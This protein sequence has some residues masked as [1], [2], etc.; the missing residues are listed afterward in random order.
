LNTQIST[1]VER[2]EQRGLATLRAQ[3]EQTIADRARLAPHMEEYQARVTDV[4]ARQRAGL[5][6]FAAAESTLASWATSHEALVQAVRE[7]RPVTMDSLKESVREVR[8]LIQE[9]RSL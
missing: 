6:V 3:L 1:L 9:W 4:R 5:A 2:G 7:R 8:S